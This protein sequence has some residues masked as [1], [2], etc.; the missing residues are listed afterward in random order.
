MSRTVTH[1]AATLQ[2]NRNLNRI[3]RHKRCEV[4]LTKPRSS[5]RRKGTDHD[6]INHDFA[7]GF[8]AKSS[9][10]R[11]QVYSIDSH[12]IVFTNRNPDV[13]IDYAKA[14]CEACR[15]IDGNKGKTLFR[16]WM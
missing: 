5:L 12:R 4:K 7:G 14:C 16:N 2:P 8:E 13:A 10:D 6:T 11:Y 15:V 9:L 3:Q 1:E